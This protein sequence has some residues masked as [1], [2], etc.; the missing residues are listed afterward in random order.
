M[1]TAVK[2]NEV[3]VNKSQ[4]AQ[5]VLLNMPGPPRNRGG[6]ENCILKAAIINILC[7]TSYQMTAWK[8]VACNDEQLPSASLSFTVSLKLTVWRSS[9]SVTVLLHTHSF[10][11]VLFPQHQAA[12]FYWEIV[13]KPTVHY[14]PAPN[15][16]R[17]WVIN[18]LVNIVEH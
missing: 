10:Y 8:G 5:L 18:K 2:L 12:V 14:C 11:G 17:R 16:R 3:V 9:C 7:I 15:S 1:H 6:D 13:F 4:G